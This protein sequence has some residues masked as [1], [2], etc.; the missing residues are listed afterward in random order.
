V[1]KVRV[2]I[3]FD[4]EVMGALDDQ[5]KASLD[6]SADRSEIVNAVMKFFLGREAQH[7]DDDVASKVRELLITERMRKNRSGNEGAG[8]SNRDDA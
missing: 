3:S 8:R 7:D 4:Q 2:G 1:S 6:L 5:V